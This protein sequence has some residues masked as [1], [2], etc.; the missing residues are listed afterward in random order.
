[1]LNKNN[2]ARILKSFFKS[3]TKEWDLLKKNFKDFNKY[4][5]KKVFDFID[6]K[7]IL[8]FN[9][10]RAVSSLAKVDKKSI[11]KRACFLCQKNLFAQQKKLKI[12]KDFLVVCNPYPI[13][14]EHFTIISRKHQ[15]QQI[16]PHFEEMLRIT[17]KIG[18]SYFVFYNGPQTGASAPDHMHFQAAILK[19]LPLE[20][21]YKNIRNKYAQVLLNN[22]KIKIF[23]VKDY[24][25]RSFISLESSSQRLLAEH[26]QRIYKH[27]KTVSKTKHEPKLNVIC[28]YKKFKLIVFIFPRQK[29]RPDSFFEKGKKAFLIS[30]GTTDMAGILLAVRPWDF[31]KASAKKIANVLQEVTLNSKDFSKLTEKIKNY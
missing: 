9:P 18:S 1:M 25:L 20:K 14:S 28:F 11:A 3:Q 15:P 19:K 13:F 12:F 16:L 26:F 7:L 30:P 31:K 24:Y 29:H 22:K 21:E 23:A 2:S 4:M 6:Y 8:Q 10:K 27:L 17:K 5:D